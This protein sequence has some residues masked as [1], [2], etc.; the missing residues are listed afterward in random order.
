[1]GFSFPR[2]SDQSYLTLSSLDA[3]LSVYEGGEA[4]VEAG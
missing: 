4:D 2:C 3:A 1:M